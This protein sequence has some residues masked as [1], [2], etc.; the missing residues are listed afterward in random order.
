MLFKLGGERAAA[1]AQEVAGL[2]V[3]VLGHITALAVAEGIGQKVFWIALIRLNQYDICAGILPLIGF[4]AHLQPRMNHR[5]EGLREHGGQATIADARDGLLFSRQAALHHGRAGVEGIKRHE[6]IEANHQIHAL[7]KRN[8]GMQGFL[9]CAIDKIM[10]SNFNR[11]EQ[12]RQCGAGLNSLRNGHMIPAGRAKGCSLAGIEVGSHQ[13]ELG[14]ELAKIIGAAGL[15][16]DDG[17]ALAHF[18]VG[19]NAIGQGGPQQLKCA[20]EALALHG[21]APYGR[22]E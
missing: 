1:G 19:K 21:G 8:A 9:K 12:A 20:H 17:Q 7:F 15:G 3:S 22:C 6:G 5:A 13:G 18:F 2:L 14:A 11:R 4:H 16:E 10:L